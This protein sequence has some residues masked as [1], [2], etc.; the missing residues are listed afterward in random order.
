MADYGRQIIGN[1]G[2]PVFVE[3][4]GQGEFMPVGVTIDW[5]LVAALGADT[6]INPVGVT[7]KS[8][9]KYLPH[10]Q[11]ITRV[12]AAPVQTITIGGTGVGGTWTAT[13]YRLDT[14]ALVTLS[15][16]AFNISLA[17]LL[18]ALQAP[19]AFGPVVA[20]V[21]G[22]PGTSY[23]IT[24]AI[25]LLTVNGAGL[26]GTSPTIANVLTTPV[27]NTGMYG[28]YDPAA[29]DGRQTL[30]RG[31]CAILN[32]MLVQNG[33]VG[34]TNLPSNHPGVLVGGSVWKARL[35]ATFGTASLAAGPT[36]ANLETAFPRLEYAGNFPGP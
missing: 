15:G 18:A 29:T 14:G 25:P 30:T 6:T 24:G 32:S 9:Q 16:L 17:N 7:L 8:G 23:V 33:V 27:A 19:T 3:A 1:T 31:Q 10:G 21:T 26:T 5:S 2:Y 22:T 12:T 13:G 34:F 35:K 20:A 4:T 11:V 28:P 36:F